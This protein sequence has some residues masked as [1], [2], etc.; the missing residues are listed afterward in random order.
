MAK[1]GYRSLKKQEKSK[2]KLKETKTLLPKG[3]NVTDTNF[4]V[5]KIIIRDQ[6]HQH[7]DGE[8]LNKK[9]LSCQELIGRLTHHNVGL[10][11]DALSGLKELL[12]QYSKNF[13]ESNFA[14]LIE[15]ISKLTLDE[16]RIIR[17]D[18]N[19]LL[20]TILSQV[21]ASQVAPLF[22]LLSSYLVCGLT[23]I[24]TAIRED[25]LF[26]LDALLKHN[27]EHCAN[28][29][30][31]LLPVCLDLL[32][33]GGS[34][35]RT[36]S[37]NLESKLTTGKW[38]VNVLTRIAALLQS[39]LNSTKDNE[40][41][42]STMKI[43]HYDENNPHNYLCLV[44][45]NLNYNYNE[46]R[47]LFKPSVQLSNS[48]EE[49]SM[50]DFAGALIPLLFEAFIELVPVEKNT[51]RSNTTTN[52]SLEVAMLLKNITNIIHILWN[53]CS[54]SSQWHE[55]KEWMK[56]KFG[57]SF[58]N[59]LIEGRYP[60]ALVIS[61]EEM[62]KRKKSN[63]TESN[64]LPSDLTQNILLAKLLI[65]LTDSRC[66]QPAIGYLKGC[67]RM[68]ETFS[69][70]ESSHL[71]SCFY[72]ICHSS[73]DNSQ[74]FLAALQA[75]SN[76]KNNHL[77]SLAFKALY[78]IAVDTNLS[79]LH[80]DVN[81]ISWLDSL[82]AKLTKPSISSK[83]LDMI[84]DIARRN[85]STFST[86]LDGLIEVIL[87]NL[88]LLKIDGSSGEEGQLKVAQLL[89]WVKDWDEEM[90]ETLKSGLNGNFWGH[91]VSNQI[92]DILLLKNLI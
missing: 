25:S 92:R 11:I 37:L 89:Y 21:P 73:T 13:I 69:V 84:Y 1:T 52:I 74:D 39:F 35:P 80:N 15:S 8:I 60:Y 26:L 88:A 23:H 79:H 5:K 86:S 53:L 62:K 6:V 47:I 72:E 48:I 71:I 55:D 19:K 56:N 30:S 50:K 41:K 17:K 14:N 64:E 12:T 66:W 91:S 29:A 75:L 54:S 87:D 4:K 76:S 7:K 16:S 67:L 51:V 82:P 31:K 57:K 22:P 20:A 43:I 85:F 9:N 58:L 59:A 18:A 65:S 90:V 32:S 61:K 10:K 44:D 78:N 28:A 63:N 34:G 45:K 36:L 70:D 40:I 77:S 42:H 81:F 3:Q 83:V 38:R 27:P 49:F 46:N 24:D 68:S 33:T 2:V